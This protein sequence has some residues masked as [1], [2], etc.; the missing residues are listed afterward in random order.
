VPKVSSEVEEFIKREIAWKEK[1]KPFTLVSYVLLSIYLLVVGIMAMYVSQQ[2][3]TW[4]NFVA[5]TF[6][7]GAIFVAVYGGLQVLHVS[8]VKKNL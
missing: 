5:M 2:I 6:I 4:A 3:I 8:F 7:L 1:Y